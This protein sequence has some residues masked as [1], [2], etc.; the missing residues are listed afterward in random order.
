MIKTL[1]TTQHELDNINIYFAGLEFADKNAHDEAYA[2]KKSADHNT[3]D[4]I[5]MHTHHIN[6]VFDF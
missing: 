3:L 2:K 5:F 1:K 6:M 4:V